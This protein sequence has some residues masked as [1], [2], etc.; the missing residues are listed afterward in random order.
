METAPYEQIDPVEKPAAAA[1]NTYC[2]DLGIPWATAIIRCVAQKSRRCLS[3][4]TR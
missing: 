2:P 3:R 1:G 4:Q